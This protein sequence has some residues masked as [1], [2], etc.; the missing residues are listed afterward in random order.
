[1][2]L[3]AIPLTLGTVTVAKDQRL[4][5]RARPVAEQWAHDAGWQIVSV[6][7]VNGDVEIT[8]LGPPPQLDVSVLRADFDAH[9]LAGADLTVR[10]VDGGARSCPSGS[11]TCETVAPP[12]D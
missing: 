7:A 8:A 11:G 1:V 10:L 4:T 5:R 2:V 6:N 9:G 12:G 3:V